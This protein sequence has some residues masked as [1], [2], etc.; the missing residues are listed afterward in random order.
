MDDTAT[1]TQPDDPI[2]FLVLG[3]LSAPA[4]VTSQTL[5][6]GVAAL[7]RYLQARY[8]PPLSGADLDEIANDAVARLVESGRRGLVD[9]ARNPAGYLVKIASNQAIAA[10]RRG[11]RTV[12]VDT[13]HPGLLSMTD[14][15][16]AARLDEAA[17]PD[18]IQQAMA[19][20][21]SRRDSTA[22]RVA[23]HLLDQI[24][25]TGKAPSNR[26]CAQVLGL[27]HEGVGKALRRLRTYISAAQHTA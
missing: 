19:L 6:L 18:V 23:T 20:A 21:Y 24:Q 26:A 27:S 17:T 12:P 7:R 10:I 2:Q 1:V 14:E 25:R 16:A 13:T 4:A 9:E 11:Q 3:L 15:Q 22:I 5:Q 8:S